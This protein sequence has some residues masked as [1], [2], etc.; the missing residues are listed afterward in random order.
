[1]TN[2]GPPITRDT[3]NADQS[4]VHPFYPFLS[5]RFQSRTRSLCSV[6]SVSN[7]QPAGSV[8]EHNQVLPP[9]EDA[10]FS[11]WQESEDLAFHQSTYDERKV[12]AFIIFNY[13]IYLPSKKSFETKTPMAPGVGFSMT[14]VE[15]ACISHTVDRTTLPR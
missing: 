4:T 11:Q 10:K 13:L 3:R 5:L 14:D 6:K 8:I 9:V 1:M 7:A 2:Y 12:Q 15:L